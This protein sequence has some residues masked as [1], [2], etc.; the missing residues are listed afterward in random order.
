MMSSVLTACV[1]DAEREGGFLVTLGLFWRYDE[2]PLYVMCLDVLDI[3]A[4]PPQF[5]T[6]R[7]RGRRFEKWL[8]SRGGVPAPCKL[9]NTGCASWWCSAVRRS[10]SAP[11]R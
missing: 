10:S 5:R 4:L 7:N 8:S 6:G 3:M 2:T 11:G 1:A 9:L